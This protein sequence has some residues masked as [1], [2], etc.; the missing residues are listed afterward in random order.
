MSHDQLF[1]ASKQLQKAKLR[2]EKKISKVEQRLVELSKEKKKLEKDVK[3]LSD[4][5]K[6]R[7]QLEQANVDTIE[8]LEE[9]I[10]SIKQVFV[11]LFGKETT[12][13]C[14][15]NEGDIDFDKLRVAAQMLLSQ[16]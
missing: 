5:F 2:A 7:E 1:E 14:Y 12:E 10:E 15:D 16:K 9:E 3:K 6:A 8:F 13:N 11:S 4:D